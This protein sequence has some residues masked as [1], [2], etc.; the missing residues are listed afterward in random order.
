MLNNA[1]GKVGRTVLNPLDYFVNLTTF[2]HIMLVTGLRGLANSANRNA[3]ISQIFFTGITALPVVIFLSLLAA[4]SITAQ[5]LHVSQDISQDLNLNSILSRIILFELSPL[6]VALLITSRS[7]SAI[8][9][10]LGNMQLHGEIRALKFMRIDMN[11]YLIAP[12]ILACAFCQLIISTYF[13][14][15][16]LYGGIVA[17]GFM[18][19]QR[20]FGF[21][22]DALAALTPKMLLLFVLKNLMFGTYIGAIA[23]YQ[24]LHVEHCVTDLPRQT[25][26]AIIR[27]ICLIFA[28]NLLF[29]VLAS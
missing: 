3:L 16:A 20:Y 19:S 27:S 10:D 17:A 23:C 24:A 18:Y 5:V 4:I 7:G 28:L 1:V 26:K 25:Q 6:A 21:L 15:I 29:I 14:M 11:Q 22:N 12:R 2:C 13:A 9:V 8:V